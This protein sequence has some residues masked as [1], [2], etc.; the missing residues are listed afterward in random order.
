MLGAIGAGLGALGGLGSIG[1]GLLDIFGKKKNPA[2]TANKYISQIPGTYEKYL[3]P[4][5]QAGQ[6][7]LPELQNQYKDLLGGN[8]YNK[9][10]EGYKESPG[11]KFKLSQALQAAEHA[12][13]AGGMLGTPA[14]EMQNMQLANDISSQDFENYLNHQ[15]GLYGMGLQGEQNLGNMGFQSSNSMADAISNA[16]TQQAGYGYSGAA[17]QNSTRAQGFGNIGAGFGQIGGSMMGQDFLHEL[18]NILSKSRKSET[19]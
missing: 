2:D 1:Q 13:A 6:G 16:L 19:A 10:G 18:A 15:I 4:Y 9:L 3:S 5:I 11:Y 7:A 12:N 8:V 17:G 14:H